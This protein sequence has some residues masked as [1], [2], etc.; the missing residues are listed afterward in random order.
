MD[1]VHDQEALH[2]VDLV[3]MASLE[4]QDDQVKVH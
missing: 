2:V 4:T 1:V 3:A